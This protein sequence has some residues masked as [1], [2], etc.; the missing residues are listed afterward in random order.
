LKLLGELEPKVN[1]SQPDLR[2]VVKYL[3]DEKRQWVS[4]PVEKM[5]IQVERLQGAI[6]LPLKVPN[7]AA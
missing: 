7:L 5:I 4:I 1:Q 2:R 3:T 6:G